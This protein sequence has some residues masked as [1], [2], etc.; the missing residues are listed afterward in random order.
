MN[1]TAFAKRAVFRPLLTCGGCA[2]ALLALGACGADAPTPPTEQAQ[3]P[4]YGR[5][6]DLWPQTTISVCWLPLDLAGEVFVDTSVAPDL[7]TVV[8]EREAW[9][10]QI[11]EQQWN[12]RTPLKFVGWDACS[13]ATPTD[14]RV[15][16]MSS[17]SQP[18]SCSGKGQSCV[19]AIGKDSKLPQNLLDLNVLFGEEF[20]YS[21]R[22]EQST[23]NATYDPAKDFPYWWLPQACLDAFR[24]PWKTNASNPDHRVNI[25]DAGPH[26][27]FEAIYQSCLQVSALHEFGHIAGFQHEQYRT[28]DPAKQAACF[29]YEKTMGLSDTPL[30]VSGAVPLGPFDSESIMSYC[31]T[32]ATPTLTTEDVQMATQAYAGVPAGGEG[33][34]GAGGAAGSSAS[35]AGAAGTIG[36][37]SSGG[38][39]G[40]AAGGGATAGTAGASNAGSGG[41][42]SGGAASG[43]ATDGGT[44]GASPTGTGA[45]AGSSETEPG[46]CSVGST[47]SPRSSRAWALF[48]LVLGSIG[49]RRRRGRGS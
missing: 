13:D 15:K 36:G 34:T 3:D 14:I 6:S 46:H 39:G 17:Q 45:V 47:P 8:P 41:I 4:L 25:N 20:L 35:S 32:D 38:V 28:D 10:R 23:S 24:S 42:T 19:D 44:A 26:A 48:A 33:G 16:P 12:A 37:A 11:V 2:V 1:R 22:Y 30:Q 29:D 18:R 5:P 43:G 7:A 31:R 27:Q 40:V 9:V 21:S 49:A